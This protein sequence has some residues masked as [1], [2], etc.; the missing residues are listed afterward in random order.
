MYYAFIYPYY[1]FCITVWGNTFSSVLESLLELQKRAVRQITGAGRYDHTMPI[2]QSLNVLNIPKLYIYS[3]LFF[4]YFFFFAYFFMTNNTFHEHDTRQRKQFRPPL[5][6]SN[7]RPRAMHTFLWRIIHFMNMIPDKENN[8]DLHWFVPIRGQ[9]QW[10]ALGW[11]TIIILLIIWVTTTMFKEDVKKFIIA[12]D[13]SL[14]C[15]WCLINIIH[16]M[17]YCILLYSETIVRKCSLGTSWCVVVPSRY[18][19]KYWLG[20]W[21]APSQSMGQRL[22]MNKRT[23]N[24]VGTTNYS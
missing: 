2:F 4:F 24:K 11:K 13:V 12:N 20:A 23:K 22:L 1:T 10:D 16:W 14:S 6:R 8:S 5:V 7:Q 19:F 18:W 17:Y 21:S 3:V 9:E 15:L